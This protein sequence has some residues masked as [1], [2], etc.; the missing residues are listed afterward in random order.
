M[1]ATIYSKAGSVP[2]SYTTLRTNLAINPQLASAST[3]WSQ[4]AGTG[5][6]VTA[7]RASSAAGFSWWW[8]ITFTTA[9]TAPGAGVFFGQGAGNLIPVLAST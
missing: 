2:A 6:A 4:F 3:G 9:P 7:A 5:G 1:P 8:Q